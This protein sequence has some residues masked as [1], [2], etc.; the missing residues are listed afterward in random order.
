M[1]RG[2]KKSICFELENLPTEDT[3]IQENFIDL[4][5]DSDAKLAFDP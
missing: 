5:N 3:A 1:E 2:D 4:I